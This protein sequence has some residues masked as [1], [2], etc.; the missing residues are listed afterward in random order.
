MEGQTSGGARA[1]RAGGAAGHTR[2][3]EASAAGEV[4]VLA[5]QGTAPPPNAAKLAAD[6]ADV[7]ELFNTDVAELFNAINEGINSLNAKF[8]E[9]NARIQL[10][11]A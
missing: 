8:E 11:A 1:A 4:R 7:A 2:Q 6:V 5:T 10:I 9:I 3:Q